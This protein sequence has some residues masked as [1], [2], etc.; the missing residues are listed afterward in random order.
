MLSTKILNVT[1][2][3]NLSEFVENITNILSSYD[4]IY[5]SD[6]DIHKYI[7]WIGSNTR[8][9]MIFNDEYVS[10]NSEIFKIT[11]SKE[12]ASILIKDDKISLGFSVKNG[13]QA[14]LIFDKGSCYISCA[15]PIISDGDV[16]GTV[17]SLHNTEGKADAAICGT[18]TEKKLVMTA[19]AFLGKQLD[20]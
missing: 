7:N 10:I 20:P 11:V 15:F 12:Q 2:S 6:F 19:A 4:A 9:K 14:T 8:C 17:A 1:N 13:P 18:D 3:I 16:I 5:L